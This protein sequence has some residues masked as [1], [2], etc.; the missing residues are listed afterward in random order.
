MLSE[1]LRLFRFL[2]RGVREGEDGFVYFVFLVED[3]VRFRRRDFFR[4]REV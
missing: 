4:L 2:W 1:D 3:L